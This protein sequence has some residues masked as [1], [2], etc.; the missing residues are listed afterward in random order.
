VRVLC[1]LAAAHFELVGACGAGPLG[2][3][4]ASSPGTSVRAGWEMG[5][6]LE[7]GQLRCFGLNERGSLG[8]GQTAQMPSVPANVALPWPAADVAVGTR[9]GCARSTDGRVACWGD[10]GADGG[11]GRFGPSPVEVPLP[12]PVTALDF[13]FETALAIGSDGRTY[14]WGYNREGSLGRGDQRELD[15]E[16]PLRAAF[17]QRFTA[18]SAGQGHACGIDRGGALWCWG[19]NTNNELGGN[20]SEA[21]YRTPQRIFGDSI[22]D[23][24]VGAFLTCA[25]RIDGS[26]SCWGRLLNDSGARLPYPFPTA[27]SLPPVKRVECDWFHACALTE[28]NELYCWGRGI[29]GQLGV[30]NQAE[31]TP[32]RV[33]SDVLDFSVGYFF[34]CIRTAN[35]VACTGDND[36][37]Q[38]GL[39]DTRRRNAFTLQGQ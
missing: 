38:L 20:L 18:V 16:P 31:T 6:R 29:E 32:R 27:I 24:A 3:P 14:G 13:R 10:I 34:T 37:G 9:S 1:F 15:F 19:R 22:R 33:A 26:V 39:G 8:I 21:Q 4:V 25:T 23:V 30:G 11:F 17:E 36:N 28:N 7:S 5:C 12:V 2:P 35:G